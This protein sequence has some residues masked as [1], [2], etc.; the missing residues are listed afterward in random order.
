MPYETQFENVMKLKAHGIAENIGLSNVNA[1][2]LKRA[3]KIGG[4]PAQ[5][6]VILR[7]E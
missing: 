5:G 3:I 4:T 1:E 6:G 2:Q 7:A